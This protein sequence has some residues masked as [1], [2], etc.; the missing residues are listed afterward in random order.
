ME[1]QLNAKDFFGLLLIFCMGA[2]A[3]LVSTLYGSADIPHWFWIGIMG[4]GLCPI[5]AWS[6]PKLRLP[7]SVH[8]KTRINTGLDKLLSLQRQPSKPMNEFIFSAVGNGL[9]FM[10]FVLLFPFMPTLQDIANF[11]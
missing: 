1:F 2:G 8:T 10:L 4:L 11:F 5:W 7:L 3:A 9:V 6:Y